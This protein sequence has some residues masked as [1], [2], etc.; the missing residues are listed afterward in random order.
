MEDK[1]PFLGDIPLVGR[2]FQTKAEEYFKRNLVIFVTCRLI[3]PDGQPIHDDIG[4]RKRDREIPPR[5]P[6]EPQPF[7]EGISGKGVTPMFMGK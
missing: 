2:L 7:R 5:V 3:G 4:K 6:R 1:V